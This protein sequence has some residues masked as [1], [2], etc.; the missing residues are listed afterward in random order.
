MAKCPRAPCSSEQSVAPTGS[1]ERE[2]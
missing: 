1:R 2:A